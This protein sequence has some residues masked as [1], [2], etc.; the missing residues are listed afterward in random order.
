MI[1]QRMSPKDWLMLLLLSFLWGGSFFFIAVAVSELPPLTIVTMRVGMASITLWTILIIAGYE[2][3]KSLKL[4]RSFLILGLLSNAIPFSL[5]VWGQ[6]HITSGLASIINATTP[7]FTVLIAGTLL[8]D[9]HMTPA[10][11]IGVVIGL[12]G[13]IV[14]IGPSTLT[15]VGADTTA[16]LAIM[17]AAVSYGFA[18]VYGRRFKTMGISPVTTAVGQVT[19]ATIILL[20]LA[21]FIERPDQLANPSLKVWL[22]VIS[23]AVFSTAL[24]YILFFRILA[25]S[26]ATN[27]VLV[28]FLVPITA[29]LLGW[30]AL[31]EILHAEYFIG[32]VFIGLGLAAIDGR[33]WDKAKI[34]TKRH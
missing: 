34:L 27:V 19:C 5:I 32:M 21:F 4:W 17:A 14:L 22:A 8:T 33:L 1:N 29:N 10:K 28:T 23:L 11:I 26:G 7:L 15:D 25:S 16:Q 20:P 3:P 24:A 9:E 12:L 2:I 18:T 30:L 6:T 31:N 13:V